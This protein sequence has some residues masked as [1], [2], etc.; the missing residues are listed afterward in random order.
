MAD[1]CCVLRTPNRVAYIRE[2]TMRHDL[3]SLVNLTDGYVLNLYGGVR[4]S[5]GNKIH[6]WNCPHIR[7]MTVPPRKIWGASVNQLIQWLEAQG[8][9]LDPSAPTC[10]YIPV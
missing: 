5:V 7:R 3:D 4:G 1:T 10:S 8:G 2:N 9:N 6:P